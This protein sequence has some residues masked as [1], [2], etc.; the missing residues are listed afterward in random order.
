MNPIDWLQQWYFEQCNDLREHR[1]GITIETLDN[2]G[3]RVKVDLEGTA[4]QGVSMAEVGHP[5]EINHAGIQG[6]Q[7][8]LHCQVE[9][10]RFVGAGGP[11]SLV[12][13]CETFKRWV[14]GN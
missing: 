11:F 8:W 12:F 14:E 2:P 13:I 4:M 3:W 7:D 6:R 10:N 5:G 1:H 9:E